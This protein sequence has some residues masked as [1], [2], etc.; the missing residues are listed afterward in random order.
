MVE[1][2][3]SWCGRRTRH[4]EAETFINEGWRHYGSVP[5]CPK[6]TK[7]VKKIDTDKYNMALFLLEMLSKGR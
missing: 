4:R 7:I 1:L 3:C 2:M 5:Y 6:C